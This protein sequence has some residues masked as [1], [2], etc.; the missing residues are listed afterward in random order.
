[1][2]RLL[3]FS[4][5]IFLGCVLTACSANIS[6]PS[7]SPTTQ[8]VSTL[9]HLAPSNT[10]IIRSTGV[11]SQSNSPV[12]RPTLNN[13]NLLPVIEAKL[14]PIPQNCPSVTPAKTL[15][16][17]FGKGI[18][19][20]PL[21]AITTGTFEFYNTVT[22]TKY[23]YPQKLLWEIEPNYNTSVSVKGF[24]L[25]DNTPVWFK[26]GNEEPTQ[27]L[28]FDP[29]KPGTRDGQN[30]EWKGYPSYTYIPK[31]GC[32]LLEAQWPDGSWQITIAAGNIQ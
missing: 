8:P 17:S 15:S 1:M 31:A 29:A 14:G 32:Y 25:N 11:P 5:T 20:T 16:P 21:W 9:S 26:T 6:T 18:G 27:V 4:G 19:G 28:V 2:K 13:S 7:N 3:L 22:A 23:G 12:A 30:K 10:P 24:N